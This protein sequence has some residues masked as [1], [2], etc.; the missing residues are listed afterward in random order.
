[1]N[2]DVIIHKLIALSRELPTTT[3][4][5][6][7]KSSSESQVMQDC[8]FSVLGNSRLYTLQIEL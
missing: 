5:L 1:M 3:D 7:P 6:F 4:F 8:L 2:E